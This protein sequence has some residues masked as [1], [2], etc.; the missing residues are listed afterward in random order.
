MEKLNSACC[1]ARLQAHSSASSKAEFGQY[2]GSYL[3]SAGIARTYSSTTLDVAEDGVRRESKA[4]GTKFHRRFDATSSMSFEMATN[5]F[6]M[7]RVFAIA[8]AFASACSVPAGM[9]NNGG[10]VVDTVGHGNRGPQV[11][12]KGTRM[13]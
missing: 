6:G 8:A 11:G 4:G 2:Q 10:G 5:W 12:V 9:R 7:G 13:Q 1:E 3:T